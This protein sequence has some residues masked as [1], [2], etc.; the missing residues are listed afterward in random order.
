MINSLCLFKNFN[1]VSANH[2]DQAVWKSSVSE[3]SEC[4]YGSGTVNH[5]RLSVVMEDVPPEHTYFSIPLSKE[6]AYNRNDD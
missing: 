3:L 2:S 6:L 5:V 1:Y 4:Y